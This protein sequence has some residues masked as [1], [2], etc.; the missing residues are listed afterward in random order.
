[1]FKA[2]TFKSLASLSL[3]VAVACVGVA[4]PAFA[5]KKKQPEIPGHWERSQDGGF[6]WV[7]KK[8]KMPKNVEPV[9]R[10]HRNDASGG[11]VIVTST[12]V[13]RDHRKKIIP[14]GDSGGGVVITS[15]PSDPIVRD[16]RNNPPSD[17]IVRDH[18][19]KKLFG[20]EN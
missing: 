17:P 11:G 6:D 9:V 1:M 13:V 18:R 5:K 4:D 2:F 10:D 8:S 19:K 16:H 12:P 14:A 20:M 15:Q 3:I 7:G